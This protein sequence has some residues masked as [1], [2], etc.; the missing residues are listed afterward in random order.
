MRISFENVSLIGCTDEFP[1]CSV[2]ENQGSYAGLFC[3]DGKVHNGVIHKCFIHFF[4]RTS[5]TNIE[6][7]EE[8]QFDVGLRVEHVGAIVCSEKILVGLGIARIRC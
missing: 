7:E 5:L 1:N 6:S 3:L 2:H 4:Q 8:I